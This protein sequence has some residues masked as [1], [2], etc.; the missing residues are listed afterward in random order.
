MDVV[1][2]GDALTELK[3]LPDNIVQLCITSPPYW[4]LRDYSICSCA[5]LRSAETKSSTLSG[6][7]NAGPGSIKAADPDC[8]KCA[9]SGKYIDVFENQI[10]LEPTPELYVES[11]VK[12]AREI[13]RVLRDDGVFFMV[14]GDTYWDSGGDS[15]KQIGSDRSGKTGVDSRPVGISPTKPATR[16][17]HPYLKP[18]DMCCIPWLVG[19]ALQR[20]GWWLRQDDIWYKSNPTPES[21]T[22]RCTK[23]HEYILHLTKS[24]RYYWNADAIREK[25]RWPDKRT[26]GRRH[27]S[28]GKS[29]SGIYSNDSASFH[30][31]GRNKRSVWEIQLRACAEPHFATYPLDLPA[32]CIRA[33]S[34]E[35]DIVLDPFAGTGTT[36]EAAKKA[37]RRY[38]L[39]DINKECLPMM[40]RRLMQE[41]LF[42][43]EVECS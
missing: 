24:E 4:Q 42:S 29:A 23:A 41:V 26:D 2:C 16:Q 30:P 1:L 5:L 9:G 21:V 22:D 28:A 20:D 43:Q 6:G 10:G 31:N 27:K 3:K 13:R 40:N 34:K 18:K 35:G 11:I 38:I 33:A 17:K 15:G 25:H 19:L 7:G 8:P 12:I 32:F 37:G 14:I 36:G 39:I